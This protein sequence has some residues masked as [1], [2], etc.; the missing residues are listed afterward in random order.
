MSRVKQSEVTKLSES[1]RQVGLIKDLWEMMHELWSPA[2]QM[3]FGLQP[4]T[5]NMFLRNGF[6]DLFQQNVNLIMSDKLQKWQ[7]H[8]KSRSLRSSCIFSCFQ[9]TMVRARCQYAFYAIYTAI[10]LNWTLK[11]YL[12]RIYIKCVFAF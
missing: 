11:K 2:V 3:K 1:D 4:D 7:K 5:K 6:T 10:F 8:H 9:S 12:W